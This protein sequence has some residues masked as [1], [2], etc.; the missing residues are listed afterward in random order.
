[1]DVAGK[2]SSKLNGK[3]TFPSSFP[4]MNKLNG[5][6]NPATAKVIETSTES[7]GIIEVGIVNT[8]TKLPEISG[9]PS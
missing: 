6:V 3:A 1:M 7:P 4:I 8:S 5:E 2:S 9:F